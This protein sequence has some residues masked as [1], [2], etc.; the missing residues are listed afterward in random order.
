MINWI[1]IDLVSLMLALVFSLID[2]IVKVSRLD[3]LHVFILGLGADQDVSRK[4]KLAYL[5]LLYI[6]L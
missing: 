2:Q 3:S 6:S 5:S 4:F 1:R